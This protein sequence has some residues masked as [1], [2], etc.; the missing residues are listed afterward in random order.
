MHGMVTGNFSSLNQL[1]LDCPVASGQFRSTQCSKANHLQ[2]KSKNPMVL[3][4]IVDDCIVWALGRR[5][6]SRASA[7]RSQMCLVVQ[8]IP[9]TN[10]SSH[11]L[12]DSPNSRL[13]PGRSLSLTWAV[14]PL[15]NLHQPERG[16]AGG[17]CPGLAWTEKICNS[18]A[19]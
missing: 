4:H 14:L 10:L 9:S 13:Y 12:H 1:R 2:R 11:G 6:G 18:Q 17:H 5:A 8:V 3:A 16:N 19:C 7:T 15:R